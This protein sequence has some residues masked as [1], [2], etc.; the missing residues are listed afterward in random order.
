[1]K[2]EALYAVAPRNLPGYRVAA[3]MIRNGP[4]EGR[5]KDGNL[6]ERMVEG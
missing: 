1:M 5:I 2:F 6:R 4:M 3:S